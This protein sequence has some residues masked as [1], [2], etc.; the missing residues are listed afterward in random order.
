MSI[1]RRAFLFGSVSAPSLVMAAASARAWT[2][3]PLGPEDGA[4]YAARCE[5]SPHSEHLQKAM[6][7]L[8]QAG[9]RLPLQTATACPVCGCNI[10][11]T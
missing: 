5:V 10:A 8:E 3:Q 9:I 2:S 4:L 7:L 6:G 11:P 1:S